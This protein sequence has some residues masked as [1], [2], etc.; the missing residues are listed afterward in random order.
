MVDAMYKTATI[1]AYMTALMVMVSYI[2]F[3]N[4][5]ALAED[6]IQQIFQDTKKAVFFI[7]Y[8]I[9]EDEY[10]NS[11]LHTDSFKEHIKELQKGDYN[12]ISA[13][14][15]IDSLKLGKNLKQHSVVI[16]FEGGYKSSLKNAIPIL[17][18]AKLPFTI[19]ITPERIDR[20]S[21][22]YMS[23]KEIKKLSKN[24]L[25]TIGALPFSYTHIIYLPKEEQMR[26]WTR[27]IARF[28]EELGFAPK[29]FAW[30]Y[31]EYTKASL[32]IV[33]NYEFKA[34]FGQHSGVAYMGSN[35]MTLPRFSMTDEYGDLDRF[36]LAA[37]S[38]PLPVSSEQ[39]E[40][41]LVKKQDIAKISFQIPEILEEKKR[42]ACFMSDIGKLNIEFIGDSL[43][44]LNID[45]SFLNKRLRMNCT[46]PVFSYQYE[47][48]KGK[49]YWRWY[50]RLFII[51]D[52]VE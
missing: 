8:R 52:I 25:V 27:S 22:Y 1:K 6:E 7:Y 38:F 29:I 33:K 9:G 35:F 36:K 17:L 40:Y 37:T 3:F 45:S 44:N 47:K 18:E 15:A 48:E 16:T 31:G 39:P 28:K 2:I 14:D 49:Q 32:E 23:W 5:S 21:S 26:S 43:V 4:I 12:V 34:G 30:P 13:I 42:I 24:R 46:I 10:P 20:N 41:I 11:N 50:G 19:F 51:D